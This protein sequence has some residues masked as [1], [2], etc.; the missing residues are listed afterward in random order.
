MAWR[1]T[2]LAL[3]CGGNAMAATAH[4]PPPADCDMP[5]HARIIEPAAAAGTQARAYWLD[6]RLLQWPA[7]TRTGRFRLYHSAHGKLVAV[8]GQRITGADGAL[9]LEP[10][11]AAL[12]PSLAT[13]FGFVPAGVGL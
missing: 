2:L 9:L 12:P 10:T 13:R 8:P 6:R 11:D 7:V 3:L 5:S 1:W 4:V